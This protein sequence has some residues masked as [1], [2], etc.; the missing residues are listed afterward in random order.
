MNYFSKIKQFFSDKLFKPSL[1][2]TITAPNVEKIKP[3]TIN[4]IKDV[5]GTAID[6]EIP[7]EDYNDI[8]S[9]IEVVEKKIINSKPILETEIIHQIEEDKLSTLNNE[10]EIKFDLIYNLT[11]LLLEISNEKKIILNNNNNRVST[12]QEEVKEAILSTSEE[13]FNQLTDSAALLA[14]T[15]TKKTLNTKDEISRIANSLRLIATEQ[16]VFEKKHKTETDFAN[17]LLLISKKKDLNSKEKEVSI[18]VV[19][20]ILLSVSKQKELKT[21]EVISK[22]AKSIQLLTLNHAEGKKIENLVVEDIITFYHEDGTK[23]TLTMINPA[24]KEINNGRAYS[25]FENQSN[26]TLEDESFVSFYYKNGKKQTLTIL[27]DSI[28]IKENKSTEAQII[29]IEKVP[30]TP[31][32]QESQQEEDPLGFLDEE[33]ESDLNQIINSKDFIERASLLTEVPDFKDNK[34]YI[35]EYQNSDETSE[36]ALE[37]LVYANKRLV[38][39]ETKRYKFYQSTAFTEDDMFQ[40]GMIGLMKAAKRFDL[41]KGF[42]FSTYALY[43]IRQEITRGILNNSNTVRIPVYMGELVNK[44]RRMERKSNLNFGAIDYEWIANELEEPLEK[45]ID[46]VKVRNTFMTN[47]SLDVPI[48]TD[49]SSTLGEF[50][51]DTTFIDPSTQAINNSLTETINS[52]LGNLKAR[53]KDILIKRFG[54]DGKKPRTLET[55]GKDYN[56]TRERIRQIEKKALKR[57]QKEHNI[58]KLREYYEV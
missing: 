8:N 28:S 2:E 52:L 54:L 35:S 40:H 4:Y 48:G 57:L 6:N 29:N 14:N 11:S 43:W 46:A 13:R 47:V 31:R 41:N 34:A 55:I 24:P 23:H 53:E 38:F 22:I 39:K 3:E 25:G 44:V 15:T 1:K 37:M 18:S 7:S 50:I 51:E 58:D 45:V 49:E 12:Q 21:K 19:A 30:T 9:K 27:D 20:S 17:T 26:K 5:K 42:E 16:S 56:V 36:V 10:S 32:I 33:F